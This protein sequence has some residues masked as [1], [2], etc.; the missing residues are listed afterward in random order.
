MLSSVRPTAQRSVPWREDDGRGDRA[1]MVTRVRG[2]A[3]GGDA[4]AV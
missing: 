2:R 4:Y 1:D 3:D